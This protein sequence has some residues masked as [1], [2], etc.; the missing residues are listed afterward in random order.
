MT[1]PAILPCPRCHFAESAPGANFCSRCG[2]PLR[3]PPCPSCG[4]PAQEGDAFCNQC[5]GA[6]EAAGP[7]QQALGARSAGETRRIGVAAGSPGSGGRGA[8]PPPPAPAASAATGPLAL[9]T[10][11]VAWTAAGMMALVLIVFLVL[12][13]GGGPEITLSPGPASPGAPRTGASGP[14]PTALGP[15]SAVDLASMTPREAATRLF[16]RVMTAV[17]NE[18]RDEANLF[19]PMAIASYDRIAALSLDDRFHLSMLHAVAGNGPVALSV[20]EAGLEIRP[21]HLLCL[22]AAAQ[23]AQLVGDGERARAHYQTFID[24]FEAEVAAG[25][26]EYG[27]DGGHANLLPALRTEA[28]VYL[29]EQR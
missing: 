11:R 27:W 22:A 16:D 21:T 10:P 26:P 20:A 14:G 25:L 24:S 12:R 5:G 6:L 17:E 4:A 7:A 29:A 23:A 1:S 2:I 15:T 9:A 18:N 28:A 3:G 8:T 19:L 13:S